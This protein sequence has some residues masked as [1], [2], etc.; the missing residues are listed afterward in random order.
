MDGL[1]YGFSAETIQQLVSSG[2]FMAVGVRGM[3]EGLRG[4]RRTEGKLDLEIKPAK[5]KVEELKDL[6]VGETE[7]GKRE[8]VGGPEGGRRKPL[9]L[10]P[11]GVKLPKIPD[12]MLGTDASAKKL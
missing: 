10:V 5:M 12:N 6:Q 4:G 9:K 1:K 2:V 7:N 8:M 3:T 11:D